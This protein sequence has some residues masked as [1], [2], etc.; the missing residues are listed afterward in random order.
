[1]SGPR[2]FLL[3]LIIIVL[4][5]ILFLFPSTHSLDFKAQ[6][7]LFKLRGPRN[8]SEELVIIAI[9][10]ASF[11]AL[12]LSWPFPREYHAKLIENLSLAG[13]KLIVFD[14]EFTENSSPGA[15]AYL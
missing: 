12:N 13:A 8:P 7:S 11:S 3:A 2:S 5:K 1:M 14:V 4:V 9:D 6:D 15:D 10:D